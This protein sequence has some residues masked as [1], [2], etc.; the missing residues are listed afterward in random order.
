MA[1]LWPYPEDAFF[2]GAQP[3]RPSGRAE[4]DQRVAEGVMARL[5][6]HDRTGD[7]RIE[8]DV[9]NRVAIL[10][11]SVDSLEV[12]IIAGDLAW[13]TP[14]IADVCNMLTA[15]HGDDEAGRRHAGEG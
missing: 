14:G 2:H 5:L 12:V 4:A 13:R 9:Q 10:S 3:G 1:V 7:Q 8:V 15:P 11:G 6:G